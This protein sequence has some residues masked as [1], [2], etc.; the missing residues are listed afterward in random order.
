MQHIMGTSVIINSGYL[1][2]KAIRGE[3][4]P[5]EKL[6]EGSDAKREWS[7][8]HQELCR[9]IVYGIKERKT[10]EQK[11]REVWTTLLSSVTDRLLSGMAGM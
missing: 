10:E 1:R 7:R 9:C 8:E 5:V 6:E 11:K 2:E 3:Y 4:D